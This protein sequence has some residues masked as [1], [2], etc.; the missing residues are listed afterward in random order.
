M[1]Q[2]I[3]D[4]PYLDEE[5][6]E[7]MESFDRGEWHPLEGRELADARAKLDEAARTTREELENKTERM[8][9]RMTRSDMIALKAAAEREGL[10]YQS[11]VT[12]VLHKFTSG[13][14]VD[15]EEVRKVLH[16]V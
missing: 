12:S 14:L 3:V 13:R 1:E 2:V 15:I 16:R 4:A 5:E 9:I 10:P 8:N 11:L 7:M 6:R